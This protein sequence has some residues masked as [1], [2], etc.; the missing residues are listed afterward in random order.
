MSLATSKHRWLTWLGTCW[1][2][3]KSKPLS[4][5]YPTLKYPG[6]FLSPILVVG[7][8]REVCVQTPDFREANAKLSAIVRNNKTY[9]T[10]DIE[11]T[12]EFVSVENL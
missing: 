1:A 2:L 3:A 12:S 9:Y 10:F 5:R 11:A 4:F 8:H 7:M 6:Q